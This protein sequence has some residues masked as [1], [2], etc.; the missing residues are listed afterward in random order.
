MCQSK[1]KNVVTHRNMVL[2]VQ[3][4]QKTFLFFFLFRESRCRE[5]LCGNQSQQYSS[6]ILYWVWIHGRTFKDC[7]SG[8]QAVIN[9]SMWMFIVR[10]Q[11]GKFWRRSFQSFFVTF[12]CKCPFSKSLVIWGNVQKNEMMFTAPLSNFIRVPCLPFFF[13]RKINPSMISL[14]YCC[15]W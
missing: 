4:A 13:L 5:T 12:Q 3:L 1:I 9:L 15:S 10:E 14:R 7:S 2:W 6:G 11:W 8:S